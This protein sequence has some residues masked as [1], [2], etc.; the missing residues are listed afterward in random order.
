VFFAI[1]N[2]IWFLVSLAAGTVVGAAAVI[3][4]KQFGK[5]KTDSETSPELVAA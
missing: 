2:L 1:G 5:P 3:A 4:A